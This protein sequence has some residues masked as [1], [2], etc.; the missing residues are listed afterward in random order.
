VA[1]GDD[2]TPTVMASAAKRA[3]RRRI[4]TDP[5]RARMKQGV[6]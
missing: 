4:E 2:G 3:E 1:V 6:S 5:D